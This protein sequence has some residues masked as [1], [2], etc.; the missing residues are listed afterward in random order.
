MSQPPLATEFAGMTGYSLASF[1]D[2]FS[3][4]DLLSEGSSV[5]DVSSFGCPALRECTIADVQGR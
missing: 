5:G 1:H 2:L 3:D 4:D